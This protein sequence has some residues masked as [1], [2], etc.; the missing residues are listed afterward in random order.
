MVS[1]IDAIFN[2]NSSATEPE[3]NGAVRGPRKSL[4]L[5]DDVPTVEQR[6]A[7]PSL[8]LFDDIPATNQPKTTTPEINA[9]MSPRYQEP[10]VLPPNQS[11]SS[12]GQLFLKGAQT[13][14]I[15]ANEGIARIADS[16]GDSINNVG[17]KLGN[18]I[19]QATGNIPTQPVEPTLTAPRDNNSLSSVLN[20]F[21]QNRFDYANQVRSERD[22]RNANRSVDFEQVKEDPISLDTLR[23]AAELSAESLPEMALAATKFVGAPLFAFNTANRI[24]SERAERN[25]RDPRDVSASEVLEVAPAAVPIAIGERLGIS[26]VLPEGGLMRPVQKGFREAA[27][28][29][30]PKA[31]KSPKTKALGE[32]F[33]RVG[34]A[35]LVEGG[36][37][38]LQESAEATAGSLGTENP[39][40]LSEIVDQGIQGAIA[41]AGLGTSGRLATETGGPVLNKAQPALSKVNQVA[42]GGAST[43]GQRISNAGK[44]LIGKGVG[45]G[46]TQEQSAQEEVSDPTISKVVTPTTNQEVNT[47]FEVVDA[48]ELTPA[49]KQGDFQPRERNRKALQS[50]IDNIVNNFDPERVG[51]SRTSDTG[52]PIISNDPANIVESGNGRVAAIQRIFDEN[53]KA[54][55]DYVEFIR[56]KG[57]DVSGVD[58]PVLVRRRT[59]ELDPES[60]QAFI[61]DSN[62]GEKASISATERARIDAQNISIDDLAT[63]DNAA[64]IASQNN[65]E[66]I[67]RFMNNA[68]TANDRNSMASEDGSLSQQGIKRIQGAIL[69][70][71]Y[72]SVD[73]VK[74]LLESTDNNVK[75]IGNAMLNV[76]GDFAKAKAGDLP[77]RLDITD[78]IIEALNIISQSRADRSDIRDVIAQT[79]IEKGA[80]DAVTEKLIRA[81]YNEDLT[82][83]VSQKKIE[84]VLQYYTDQAS[85]AKDSNQ[86]IKMDPVTAN[87]ILDKA[88]ERRNSGG[89]NTLPLKDAP[90]SEASAMQT[91]DTDQEMSEPVLESKT[92]AKDIQTPKPADV[93]R[94]VDEMNRF[95]ERDLTDGDDVIPPGVAGADT[96]NNQFNFASQSFTNRT[97]WK[98]SIFTSAGF[99]PEVAINF[100]P[101]RQLKIMKSQMAKRYNITV[102][103]DNDA[104]IK[105]ALDQMTDMFSNLEQFAAVLNLP[106]TALG[107]NMDKKGKQL[108]L[109]IE[110]KKKPYLG[111]FYPSANTIGLP[112]RTNSFAHE[113]AHALD[114]FIL[115][116]LPGEKDFAGI[117]GKIRNSGMDFEP[118]SVEEAWVNVMQSIFFERDA[119]AAEIL[120]L[121]EKIEKAR[122]ESSKKRLRQRIDRIKSGSSQIRSGRT[123]YYKKASSIG[124]QYWVKPTEMLARS[125]EAYI[126][127]KVDANGGSLEAVSKSNKGYMKGADQRFRETFPRNKDRDNIFRAYDML[128]EN[129]SMSTLMNPNGDPIKTPENSNSLDPDAI[130]SRSKQMENAPKGLKEYLN[131]EVKAYQQQVRQIKNE[132]ERPTKKRDI[133]AKMRNGVGYVMSS[134]QQMFRVFE[135]RNKNSRSLRLLANMF[136]KRPGSGNFSGYIDAKGNRW[137]TY[138]EEVDTNMKKFTNIMLKILDDNGGIDYTKKGQMKDLRDALLGSSRS[139]IPANIRKA[140]GELRKQVYD[141]MWRHGQNSGME[142]GFVKD[143]AFINRIM[144]TARISADPKKFVRVASE[145]Y[146][147]QLDKELIDDGQISIEQ[148]LEV[149]IG[150]DNMR[151]A[152]GKPKRYQ[153]RGSGSNSL[154]KK[155][156]SIVNDIKNIREN[157]GNPQ[158]IKELQA[159]AQEVARELYN[160]ELKADYSELSANSWLLKLTSP[161][162]GIESFNPPR[163]SFLKSRK[164]PAEADVLLENF[165]INNPVELMRT[166]VMQMSTEAGWQRRKDDTNKMLDN[167]SKEGVDENDIRTIEAIIEE[168]T[169]RATREFFSNKT[170]P[171]FNF[172]RATGTLYLL[173]RAVFASLP[174]ALTVGLR[175]G[176]VM[177]GLSA[178]GITIKDVLSNTKSTKKRMEYAKMLGLVADAVADQSIANRVGGTYD[179][180]PK[181]DKIM[182]NMFERSLLAPLTRKQHAAA[183]AVGDIVLRRIAKNIVEAIDAEGSGGGKKSNRIEVWKSDMVEFGI[184]RSNVIDFSRWL[185]NKDG[186][187]VTLKEIDNTPNG[188]MY[189][190]ALE[191]IRSESIQTSPAIERS[192]F[193]KSDIGRLVLGIT[194]FMFSYFENIVKATPKR[195]FRAYREGGPRIALERAVMGYLPA[196][197]N[198]FVAHT[199]FMAVRTALFNPDRLEE[200]EKNGDLARNLMAAGMSQMGLYGPGADVLVNAYGGLRYQRDLANMAVGPYAGTYLQNIQKLISPFAAGNSEKTNTSEFRSLQGAYGLMSPAISF[201]LNFVPAGALSGRGLGIANMYLTSGAASEK[202]AEII[203]GEK[204]KETDENF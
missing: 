40:S 4:G 190:I 5:F 109:R 186:E 198:L 41:G 139:D 180:D 34:T 172:L 150:V 129:M 151:A 61:N 91:Q 105:D 155:L 82:R 126:A 144:D 115:D 118:Q 133:L 26:K 51:D 11:T 52:A 177:D 185:M 149:M 20:S 202:F 131:R 73:V 146:G 10:Q 53:P 57:F 96:E 93:Q 183:I 119:Q 9:L 85:Q 62:E 142:I 87:D 32:A 117:S 36:T 171:F 15:L 162:V 55:Q 6:G 24:A 197:F 170:Q 45:K 166:Y 14:D 160:N 165:M 89:Q 18:L 124:Q 71:A 112:G 163:A 64:N 50:Q 193:A 154:V 152:Q 81:F 132:K 49:E 19:R 46:G 184:P 157:D 153:T 161:E 194:S 127:S 72:D 174:E 75:A 100:P 48:S 179:N 25:E 130:W 141:A 106:T 104:L 63:I 1:F 66:F 195:V 94:I 44:A 140:A 21:A 8:G 182:A 102:K 88:I 83:P 39:A 114:F 28:K 60:R 128:F 69:A 199:I 12:L 175:T 159:K 136:A 3:G 29:A 74:K 147:I 86:L 22:Q 56:S 42:R 30:L 38:F 67:R 181:W 113:W 17:N 178:M 16:A 168:T 192:Q 37:E 176:N 138:E 200:W 148:M 203:V 31:V 68:V 189:R 47:R 103:M 90:L 97:S 188:Q 143:T 95:E 145:V 7:P 191:R 54:A 110:K 80:I 84:D 98:R 2:S 79:D 43:V 70:K 125:F 122:T 108:K 135:A 204:G 169:G 23:F 156:R 121:E 77:P 92:E 107:L 201:G 35:G 27:K 158:K 59:D 101:K 120:R 137:G 13:T 123:E 134:S 33:E 58:R 196:A 65:S 187:G 116:R 76:A 173:P 111:V 78:N 99:D 164:L 167:L